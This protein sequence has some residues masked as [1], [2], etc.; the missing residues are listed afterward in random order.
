MIP[1]TPEQ[2]ERYRA[3]HLA[4]FGKSISVEKAQIELSALVY[5]L[6]ELHRVMQEHNWPDVTNI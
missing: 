5:I 6:I 2:L 3:I 1:I 4:R